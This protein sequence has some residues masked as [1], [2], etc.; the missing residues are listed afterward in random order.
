MHL[1]IDNRRLTQINPDD[2]LL[3]LEEAAKLSNVSI[4]K[5]EQ[6]IHDRRLAVVVMGEKSRR[7]LLSELQRYWHSQETT[8]LI[9]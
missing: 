7:I 5:I 9:Y 2:K 3:K 1:K 4:K 6:L 8:A